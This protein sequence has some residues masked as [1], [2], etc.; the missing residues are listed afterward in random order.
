MSTPMFPLGSVLLPSAVLPLHVFE[1]R[2]R[3]LVRD[4]LDGDREF[5]V[6]LIERG[7]EVGGDDQR[8]MLGTIAQILDAEE[9]PDGRWGLVAVGT[10]RFRVDRWLDD[11]PYPRADLTDWPDEPDDDPPVER[12]E[13]AR[14]CLRRVLALATE[15]GMAAAPAATEITDDAALASYQMAVLA[16][17]GPF[18]RQRVLS[19]ASARQRLGLVEGLLNETAQVLEARLA[20]A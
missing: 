6:T 17:L 10:R 15:L 8:S 3:Q 4:C 7:S 20:E 19:A 14:A 5:G 2:Y 13:T 12:V 9:Y 1:D 11:G 16:P 18:D